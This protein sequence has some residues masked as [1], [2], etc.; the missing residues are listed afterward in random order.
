M[1]AFQDI[2]ASIRAIHRSPNESALQPTFPCGTFVES[3]G[4]MVR[5]KLDLAGSHCCI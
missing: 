2:L 1:D 4:Q 3:L 5:I